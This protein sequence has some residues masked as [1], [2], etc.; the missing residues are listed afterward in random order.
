MSIETKRQ[1]LREAIQRARTLGTEIQEGRKDL[2][3]S[4]LEA[5]DTA[6]NLRFEILELE[7]EEI[8]NEPREGPARATPPE[9][10]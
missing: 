10:S 4:F 1:Q 2:N 3:G 8:A 9:F 7:I 6:R 5:C